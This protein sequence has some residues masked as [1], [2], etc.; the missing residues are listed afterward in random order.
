MRE[1]SCFTERGRG[2]GAEGQDREQAE[3]EERRECLMVRDAVRRSGESAGGWK[4]GG[5][6]G[7]RRAF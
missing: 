7:S 4:E 5:R 2:E 6:C 3:R 1:E